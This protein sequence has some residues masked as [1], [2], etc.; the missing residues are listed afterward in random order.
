MRKSLQVCCLVLLS[1]FFLSFSAVAQQSD[2]RVSQRLRLTARA[3][4]LNGWLEVL[5]DSR[6]SLAVQK[7]M[8]GVGDW[9]TAF[10]E[11]DPEYAIFK[12]K[13]PENARL[14]I[15]SD[16]GQPVRTLTLERPLAKLNEAHLIGGRSTVLV[17][18]D[19]S[20]GFGSYAGVSTQLL[21]VI[22]SQFRWAESTSSDANDV[23]PIRLPDTLKSAWKLVSSRAGNKDILWVYCRPAK[24][25]FTGR[26]FVIGY[27]RYHFNGRRW[28]KYEQLRNGIWEDD[29]QFPPRS[30][31]PWQ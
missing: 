12:A 7:E 8:W 20:I 6:L 15:S 17:A 22:E 26:E 31:F 11:G 9:S 18:V 4:G 3:N 27:V 13:P 29:E 25:A 23:Q 5:T 19:Y 16:E 10:V 24:V 30:A 21:D 14:R 2:Y 1:L 28:R